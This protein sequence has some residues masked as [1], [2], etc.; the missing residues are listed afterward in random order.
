MA[1]VTNTFYPGTYSSDSSF[2]SMTN[3]TNPV[4]K[5]SDNTTYAEFTSDIRSSTLYPAKVYWPFDVSVIPED[6]TIDSVDCNVKVCVTSTTFI[7]STS[8]RLCSGTTAKGSSTSFTSTSAT[9]RS[10]SVGDWTRSELADCRLYIYA[11]PNFVMDATVRFYG[12]DL[13]VTYTYQSEK[14]MI[15]SGG[16]WEEVAKVY[17]KINGVWTEQT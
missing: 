6:A 9:V 4:G 10:L 11:M 2:G 3:A 5:G 16:S 17:K 15:K 7:D 14:F 1:T 13:T 12:A 8:I